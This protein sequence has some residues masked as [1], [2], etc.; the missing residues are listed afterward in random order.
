MAGSENKK[1]SSSAVAADEDDPGTLV[2]RLVRRASTWA[3]TNPEINSDI[4]IFVLKAPRSSTASVT[5]RPP[6]KLV[7]IL[8]TDTEPLRAPRKV[9][10]G[11]K[12]H[13]FAAT[14]VNP[15]DDIN[16]SDPNLR[17]N[18]IEWSDD[19]DN[20]DQSILGQEIQPQ[21][22]KKHYHWIFKLRC[23]ACLHWVM[24]LIATAL[25][26]SS[27]T[28]C[29]LDLV[30]GGSLGQHGFDGMASY[31]IKN[32]LTCIPQGCD[33]WFSATVHQENLDR[34]RAIWVN[35]S[36]KT[37]ST[38]IDKDNMPRLMKSFW[39]S[40]LGCQP[41][42]NSV[43]VIRYMLMSGLYT[44]S[45]RDFGSCECD[46]DWDRIEQ[47]WLIAKKAHPLVR[48]VATPSPFSTSWMKPSLD[49]THAEVANLLFKDAMQHARWNDITKLDETQ[50]SRTSDQP[51]T[52][53]TLESCLR[54]DMSVAFPAPHPWAYIE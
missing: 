17:D 26:K 22:G 53:Q 50:S 7:H 3:N 29:C 16:V 46:L 11:H 32:F 49:I 38:V 13:L 5:T 48:S 8:T 2:S 10:E 43:Q 39:T 20:C 33:L 18:I 4:R 23:L 27:K 31:A 47:L 14:F 41:T 40:T 6:R 34:M 37:T 54:D 15:D 12:G 19:T 30:H 45:Y 42:F 51:T 25:V 36:Q 24:W 21:G 1:K 44:M 35:H 9:G 28:Q 52:L